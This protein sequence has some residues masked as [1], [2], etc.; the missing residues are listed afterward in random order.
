MLPAYVE[1]GLASNLLS[2]HQGY[3]RR[4]TVKTRMALKAIASVACVLVN[5]PQLALDLRRAVFLEHA[6]E[7]P[8][9][10]E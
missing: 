1:V 5:S 10:H 8:E 2:S 4:A 3:D 9:V 6:G 7:S